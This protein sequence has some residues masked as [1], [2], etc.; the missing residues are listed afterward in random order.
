MDFN[1]DKSIAL[2]QRT[3]ASLESLLNGLNE[4]WLF[5]QEG[6]NTWSPHVVMGHLIHSEKTNWMPRLEI[7]LS[8]KEDKT[9]DGFDRFAQLRD[10][11]DHSIPEL[12]SEFKTIRAKSI[13]SLKSKNLSN[14]DFAKTGFHPQL[15]SVT[16]KQ[17][18]STWTV[19][20]LTHIAQIVRVMAKQYSS[21]VGPWK[22]NLSILSDRTPSKSV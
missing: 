19:H 21:E 14:E 22:Q 15:G 9:F 10:Y 12:T 8:S 13:E 5:G 7:I 1:L 20:D 16:L 2:L 3:P 4:E 6:P 17:L 11:K 18:L